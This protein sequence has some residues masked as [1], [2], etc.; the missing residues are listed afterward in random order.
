[1]LAVT[2]D[3]QTT[4]HATDSVS[5]LD[6]TAGSLV[7][8]VNNGSIAAPVTYD[9]PSL[10][11]AN[12]PVA[13][14]WTIAGDGTGTVTGGGITSISFT[15]VTTIS[16]GGPS[17]T[18]HGP[19]A[20][21][22]WA[23]TGAGAG[24]VAGTSFAGFEN[25]SGAADNKDTFTLAPSGALTGVADG[26]SGGYDSL[27]VDGQRGSIVSNPTDA[28]SGTL[29][30]DGVPFKYA[31]LEPVSIGGPGNFT[32]NGADVGF[33]SLHLN[34]EVLDKDLIVVQPDPGSPTTKIQIRDC[35]FTGCD[36]ILPDQAESTSF[37]ISGT[38]SLTIN[39]GL[40][41]DT[42]QF[43]G[44][45]IVPNSDLTVNAEQIKVDPGVS[46]CLGNLGSECTSAPTS[47]GNLNFNAVDKD[48]GLSILGITT[49]IP[50]IGT[51][52]LVDISAD[53]GTWDATKDYSQGDFAFGPDHVEYKAT[54]DIS[55]TATPPALDV[56]WQALG[57]TI[58]NAA[59]VSLT[60]FAGSV[61]GK[62]SGAQTLPPGSGDLVLVAVDGYADTGTVTVDTGGATPATC[63]YSGRDITNHKLTG[64]SGGAC[65]GSVA[66]GATVKQDIVQNGSTTG[67]AHA[68]LDLEYHANVNVHGD[69][70]ITAT[71]DVALGSTI[72]VTASGKASAGTSPDK[73]AFDTSTF[74]SQGDVV[75]DT[76]GKQYIATSD[77]AASSTH[78]KD[79]T[80]LFGNWKALSDSD[81]AV[82][83]TFVLALGQSQLSG[84]SFINSSGGKV[85]I[86]S[87]VKTNVSTDGSAELGKSGAGIGVAVF[88]TDS[89]AFVDSV[90][91]TPITGASVNVSADT[92][93][94][95]PTQAEASPKGEDPNSDK[96]KSTS[97]NSPTQGASTTLV[98]AQTLPGTNNK[99]KVASTA[100]FV[101]SGTL[102]TAAGDCTYT[103]VSTDNDSSGNSSFYFTGVAGCAGSLTDGAKVYGDS[104][105]TTSAGGK[106][107]DKSKTADNGTGDNGN[108]NFNAALA[109]IVL[110]ATTKAYISPSDN[111]ATVHNIA[112]STGDDVVHAGSMNV[113]TA[114]GDA[115]N[116]KFSPEILPSSSAVTSGGG[117]ADGTYYYKVSATFASGESLP[118]TEKKVDLSGGGGSGRVVL[119]W[120]AVDGA[121]GYKIYRDSTSGGE[122]LLDT[123]GTVGTYND[124][125]SKT[126]DGSTKPTTDSP[127]A[128]I[129]IGVAVV[130]GVVNTQAFLS[131]NINV[132]AK[133]MKVET[134]A[135]DKSS[136]KA[137]SVSGAGGSSVGVAGS[138]A[139]NVLVMTTE[140]D[141]KGNTAV[142]L[143]GAN[144]ELD[145]T[146]NVENEATAIAQQDSEGKA[147]GVGASVAVNVVNDTTTAGL[148]NDVVLTGVK[149]LTINAT[150]TDAMTTDAEGGASAKGSVALSA[151]VAIA[152]SNVTTTA[153]IGSGATPL[154]IS[155]KLTAKALQTA[156]T[157][158]TAKG[159]TK[160]GNAGIGLSLALLIANHDV[161]SNLKRSLTAGGDV[162][163]EAD[164][165]STNDT[166]ATA[167]SAGAEGKKDGNQGSTDSSGKDVN[168]K[169]DDNAAV[170]ES[171]DTSGKTSGKKTPDASSG[172]S[173]GTKV[174]VAA[175][176]SIAIISAK[177]LSSFDG[178][179]D[180]VTTGATSFKTSEDA[181]STVKTNASA[182][183]GATANIAA[184]VS[185]ND[186]TIKNQ[187]LVGPNSTMDSHGLTLSA[188]M[189]SGTGANGKNTLDTEATSGAGEGKVGISGA[190][191]LTIADITTHAELSGNGARGPPHY[192]LHGSA[193][194]LSAA[195]VVDSKA[196]AKAKD[197]DAGTVGIGAGVAINIVNDTTT[198]S[199]DS[200]ATFDATSKPSDVTLSAT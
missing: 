144:L 19:G 15:N 112:T 82:A 189:N 181:D 10:T 95:G 195:S 198:A 179:L 57:S 58:I 147:S 117:L 149:D 90:A 104:Q 80:G 60:A 155:G 107:D 8:D 164:G 148:P 41:I 48:N 62:A 94:A 66:D 18:L 180:L 127:T 136:F 24:T 3:G 25:L 134:T 152:I 157:K 27:V 163:L 6:V 130:V 168:K 167:S 118:S 106:A 116:V 87:S 172:E 51:D 67:F 55:A 100:G 123:V 96:S 22:N 79:D 23:I 74:Y 12:S 83:A 151:Q 174:T 162:S 68:V 76:D 93:N 143:N 59:G 16:A 29:V 54:T 102:H 49:T 31:G 200:G 138:I 4:Y 175:A 114:T 122:T 165:I 65:T 146:S 69:T 46:I 137:K 133:S 139:V 70:H 11:V 53:K 196:N 81:A 35:V 40:G 194:N 72:D 77:V 121:T 105:Q 154:V 132:T 2:V 75:T 36:G 30:I 14:D 170:G 150:S 109:V 44:N 88:V 126:P 47:H 191:A 188:L 103:G 50:Y 42:V 135:P 171:D 124:D 166:E 111:G 129:G 85:G 64:V 13:S 34:K 73:G 182:V 9:G 177:A 113:A 92:N 97:S 186:I 156:T 63:T 71:G 84:T 161:E 183:K 98:G 7:I 86:T 61:S 160:G 101:A 173:G 110:V 37:T 159:D 140:S 39:G 199:I 176:V 38:T 153:S 91:T 1:M 192:S 193:L 131:N 190:L 119:N 108:Q 185:I 141:V 184:A 28:H 142:A 20:D 158:T 197:D 52:G 125:G 17:D 32:Y 45:Y 178:N 115:G 99:L 33:S 78:P 56:R 145:A 187:A 26:G 169:A 120:D 89:E 5:G 128:G 21:S 43:K